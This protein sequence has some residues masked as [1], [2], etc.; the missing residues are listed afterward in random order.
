MNTVVLDI[1]NRMRHKFTFTN[2]RFH[3][4]EDQNFSKN[5]DQLLKISHKI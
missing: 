4:K 5:F 2:T 1:V 3:N